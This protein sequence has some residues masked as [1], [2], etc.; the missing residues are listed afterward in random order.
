M[1]D[2][3]NQPE[4]ALGTSPDRAFFSASCRGGGTYQDLSAKRH[5]RRGESAQLDCERW[6]ITGGVGTSRQESGAPSSSRFGRFRVKERTFT[7]SVRPAFSQPSSRR[8]AE[9]RLPDASGP[10][11]VLKAAPRRDRDI[12]RTRRAALRMNP[13]TLR[14]QKCT[15]TGSE[16]R[17]ASAPHCARAHAQ[18]DEARVWSTASGRFPLFHGRS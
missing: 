15:S 3:L 1:H 7:R 2:L 16:R 18:T 9:L 13:G 6:P 17:I 10:S 5:V 14:V 4:W 11:P 12:P 8:A